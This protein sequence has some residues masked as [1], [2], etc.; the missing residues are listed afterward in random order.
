M[1]HL[2]VFISSVQ[3]E[4]RQERIAVGSYLATDD[5]LRACTVPRIFEDYP[6][7]LRP[8]PKAYLDLLRNCQ[9]Y[10]LIVASEYGSD[11]GSGLAETHEEY[12][13]AQEMKLRPWCASTG[14]ARS[15]ESPR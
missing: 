3:K 12:R 4:L 5:F 13:L 1:I 10:L 8:N 9:I 2:K 7:P 6:Q 11:A 15:V 14:L